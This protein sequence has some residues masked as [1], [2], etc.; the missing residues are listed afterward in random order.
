VRT[1]AG[2]AADVGPLLGTLIVAGGLL[3]YH[4]LILR[5]DL[6]HTRT[7]QIEEPAAEPV[8]AP[9]PARDVLLT[10]SGPPEADLAAIAADLRAYLPEGYDLSVRA[11]GEGQT[12]SKSSTDA[13]DDTGAG[14]PNEEAVT[15]TTDANGPDEP[16]RQNRIFT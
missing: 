11:D 16:D 3:A 13:G 2:I 12:L 15:E 7:E 4:L 6:R 5:D 10:L 9:A 1:A 14:A 8:A